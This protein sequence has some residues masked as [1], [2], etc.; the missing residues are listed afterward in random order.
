MSVLGFDIGGANLKIAHSD[1]HAVSSPFAIWKAPELL[2]EQLRS[3]M[4]DFPP[5]DAWALTMTAELADCFAT[6]Q[7]GVTHVTRTAERLAMGNPIHVWST[8][9][10]FITPQ[11]A[12]DDPLSVA[13]ANWHALATWAAR[14]FEFDSGLLI[15]VGSTT[16]DIIPIADR[17]AASIGRTDRQRLQS[18]ELSYHG[19]RR[20][21]LCALTAALPFRGQFCPVA[22]EWFATTLD[23]YLLL[24][25]IEENPDDLNTADGRPATVEM[26]HARMART[27]CCD[28]SEFTRDDAVKAA[29]YLADLQQQILTT[30]LSGVASRST[31]D[32]DVI[33]LSG[34]GQR[35]AE[36]ALATHPVL[37]ACRRISLTETFSP[38][39]TNAACAYAVAELLADS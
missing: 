36:R 35:L 5:A 39:I 15:D 25:E 29:Q 33:V 32:I 34:S 12:V 13:S 4:A 8:N 19:F 38:E 37:R 18:T 7:E 1:S 14:R 2:A 30:A 28:V 20:T 17:Q 27:I 26:A 9:G 16:T 11:Q 6:K 3:L 10:A 24:G 31:R 21:P 23:V 22:A